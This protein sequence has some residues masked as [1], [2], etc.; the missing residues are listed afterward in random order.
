MAGTFRLTAR[1][2]SIPLPDYMLVQRHPGESL[3]FSTIIDGYD[4][5]IELVRSETNLI[6]YTGRKK[7]GPLCSPCLLPTLW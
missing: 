1:F 4:V 2:K 6:E 5:E 3:K 7:D